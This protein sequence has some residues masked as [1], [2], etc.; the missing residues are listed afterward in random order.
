MG[1]HSLQPR[2]L[3]PESKLAAI[4][5]PALLEVFTIHLIPD[6]ERSTALPGDGLDSVAVGPS[7]IGLPFQVVTAA[8]GD[9]VFVL[10]V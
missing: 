2:A 7:S 10:V 9:A 6:V 5:V 1:P 4:F 3:F 8:R